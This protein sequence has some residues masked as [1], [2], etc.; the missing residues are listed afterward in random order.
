MYGMVQ[1][2]LRNAGV[3]CVIL[4]S[5]GIVLGQRLPPGEKDFLEVEESTKHHFVMIE[6]EGGSWDPAGHSRGEMLDHAKY[7]IPNFLRW[8]NLNHKKSSANE[9]LWDEEVQLLQF[10][11]KRIFDYPMLFI[12]GHYDYTFSDKDRQNLKE[13]LKRGGFL[14]IEDCGGS[15]ENLKQ[16]GRFAT[17]IKNEIKALFPEGEFKVLPFNHDI[18]QIP[19]KF[20]YG[21]PNINGENNNGTFDPPESPTKKRKAKGGEGFYYQ[22]RM[23]AFY[24]DVDTC[25]GWVLNGKGPWRDIPFQ[26]GENIVTYVMTHF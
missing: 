8:L 11:D 13:Y 10:S 9:T 25:C 7:F 2:M 16:N 1:R 17:R 14:Y 20:P 18:Y 15:L 24:S 4:A 21:L 5:I 26:V 12:A 19:N 22:G 6:Y 23:I 3:G